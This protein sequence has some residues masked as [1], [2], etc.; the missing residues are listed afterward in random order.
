[1]HGN[2]CPREVS[3]DVTDNIQQWRSANCCCFYIK[4]QTSNIR[5]SSGNRSHDEEWLRAFCNWV[6]QGSVR[7]I[8]RY[9]FAAGKE[10][11]QR[12]ARLR[13]VLADR[14]TQH[15]IAHLQC[16]EN[17]SLRDLTVELEFHFTANVRQC[18]QMMRKHDANHGSFTISQ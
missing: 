16:I 3:H 18:T 8:V 1:C 9:V 17:C 10:S 13:V 11:D 6:G 7:R 15:R 2:Q 14:A 4:H 5:L 12:P